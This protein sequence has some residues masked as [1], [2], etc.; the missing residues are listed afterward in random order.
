MPF[1]VKFS[2]CLQPLKYSIQLTLFFFFFSFLGNGQDLSKFRAAAD[3]DGIGAIPYPDLEKKASTLQTAKDNAFNACKDYKGRALH[4]SKMNSVRIKKEMTE[5]LAEARKKLADD[6][7]SSSSTTNS[8]KAKVKELEN[9]LA[10]VTEEIE[11]MDK[12]INEGLKLWQNL[13]DI[14]F[15]I[16]QVYAEVKKQLATS[17]SY[18]DR[19]ITKPSSSD[20][21][22]MAQYNKDVALLKG[23]IDEIDDTMDEGKADHKT[24][25]QEAVNAIEWLE[26]AQDLK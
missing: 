17:K 1:S 25:I 4:D 22:A 3:D 26:K 12:R 19:H 7:G 6:N 9:E 11:E 16:D 2:M 15:D 24:P 5:D 10:D 20:T 8:L 14:R 21:Q 13:L 23:Y 18:P